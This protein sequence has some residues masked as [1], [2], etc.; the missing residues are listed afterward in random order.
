[1]RSSSSLPTDSDAAMSVTSGLPSVNVPVLS[2]TSIST[3]LASSNATAFFTRM[4][5][6]APRPGFWIAL[7][8]FQDRR[9]AMTAGVLALLDQMLFIQARIAMLDAHGPTAEAF[10]FKRPFAAPDGTPASPIQD[11]CA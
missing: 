6:D 8:L 9:T 10:T 5:A 3:V 2:T 1:M 7:L 4:P 11:E